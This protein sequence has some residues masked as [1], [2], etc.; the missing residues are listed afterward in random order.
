MRGPCTGC[1]GRK[2]SVEPHRPQARPGSAG[3]SAAE[4][5]GRWRGA[6]RPPRMAPWTGRGG[7]HSRSS[8]TTVGGLWRSPPSARR[9]VISSTR[10]P[11]ALITSGRP[12]GRPGRE[13]RHRFPGHRGPPRCGATLASRN[14]AGPHPTT[15]CSRRHLPL[16]LSS[17]GGANGRSSIGPMARQS[18]STSGNRAD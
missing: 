7:G 17:D 10:Q 13:G 12:R 2:G 16:G 8:I 4:T 3:R 14:P 18:T 9:S 15:R 5:G 1:R 6:R 11:S